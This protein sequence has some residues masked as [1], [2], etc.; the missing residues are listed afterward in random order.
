MLGICYGVGSENEYEYEYEYEYEIPNAN[1]T[2]IC[3]CN[4]LVMET[5]GVGH[6]GTLSK[7]CGLVG[8]GE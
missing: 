1:R 2:N 8:A 4:T 3:I 5:E 7:Y 6:L